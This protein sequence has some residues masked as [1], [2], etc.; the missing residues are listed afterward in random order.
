MNTEGFS[1]RDLKEKLLK[2]ALHKAILQD[3]S[4]VTQEIID[5]TLKLLNEKASKEKP[6]MFI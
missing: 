6:K 3:E 4:C 1:G 2:A 5:S